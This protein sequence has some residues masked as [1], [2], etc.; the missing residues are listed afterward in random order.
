MMVR[1]S[2]QRK[3]LQIAADR[4]RDVVALQRH[5]EIGDHE[6]ASAAAIVALA[7]EPIG[8]KRL[9]PDQLGHGVGQLDF[10]ARARL[11]RVER[12][13][14]FGLQ[15]VAAGK[16]QVGRRGA[17]RGLLDH[18][19]NLGQAAIGRA[20]GR[21]RHIVRLAVRHFERGD[22]YCRRRSHRPRPSARAIGLAEHQLVGE[23]HREGLV[24]DDVRGRTNRVAKAERLL[25]ANGHDFAE[26]GGE[27][28]SDVE[29][30]AL[31]SR[32]VRLELE[33]RSK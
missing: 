18:A 28:S 23:Q 17:R 33:G 6:P 32:I 2:A 13:H 15:D 19:A 7:L 1:K 8:V 11:L 12:A 21:S 27:G 20:R 31:A 4:R 9:L 22:E 24:A 25:L 16:H 5:R 29:A 26:P 30:L 3:R 10:T 14:H